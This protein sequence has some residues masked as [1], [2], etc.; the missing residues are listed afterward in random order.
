MTDFQVAVAVL[1]GIMALF[2]L[3]FVVQLRRPV[4]IAVPAA[5]PGSA[6]HRTDRESTDAIGQ[7]VIQL[8]TETKATADRV[9]EVEHSVAQIRTMMAALP[10]KDSVNKLEVQ[11]T[12]LKGDMKLIAATTTATGRAVER[13]EDHL[14]SKVPT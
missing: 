13:I 12:E 1:G 9:R 8:K 4:A 7:D 14:M 11:V 10:S 3:A 5:A 2:T 6:D